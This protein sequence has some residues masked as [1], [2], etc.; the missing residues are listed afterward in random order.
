MG[1]H[2][3]AIVLLVP[4]IICAYEAGINTENLR[5]LFP[6]VST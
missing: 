3:I 5:L 6:A 2:N 1:N 4:L